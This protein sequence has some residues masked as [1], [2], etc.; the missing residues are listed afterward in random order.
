MM[1]EALRLTRA[2]RV[3]E[4]TALL[5]GGLTGVDARD[6]PPADGE[7]TMCSSHPDRRLSL[8]ESQDRRRKAW[9]RAPHVIRAASRLAQHLK[10]ELVARSRIDAH[11]KPT[12]GVEPPLPATA[13]SS[14]DC[15]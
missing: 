4:A 6:N 7:G 8:P 12:A 1:A 5:Q 3:A 13:P 15:A 14:A 2:G 11:T 9:H 10:P